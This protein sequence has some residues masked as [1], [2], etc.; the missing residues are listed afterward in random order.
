MNTTIQLLSRAG[1]RT[2]N[3]AIILSKVPES[4]QYN[5]LHRLITL[6]F[7]LRLRI[8][9]ARIVLSSFHRMAQSR[10]WITTGSLFSF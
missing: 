7:V 6:A 10:A 4:Q 9:T 2:I 5:Y 8:K 3:T 1:E